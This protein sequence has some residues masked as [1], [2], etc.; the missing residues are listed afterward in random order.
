MGYTIEDFYDANLDEPGW[1]W[2]EITM[3][4]QVLTKKGEFQPKN[5]AENVTDHFMKNGR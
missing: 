5:A 4:T 1:E 3:R 2:Y